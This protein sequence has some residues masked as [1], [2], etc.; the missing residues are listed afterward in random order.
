MGI[1]TIVC[2]SVVS[3]TQPSGQATAQVAVI[4]TGATG[5]QG[6]A[7]PTGATGPAG[8]TGATGAQGIPGPAGPA[9]AT[10]PA[11]ANGLNGA[12]GAIG[13][14]GATGPA[15]PTGDTGAAGAA[16][17]AGA[18]GVPGLPGAN[19]LPGATGLGLSFEIRRVLS[20]ALITLPAGNRSVVYLVTTP[21]SNVTLTLP[22]ASDAVSRFVTIVRVDRGRRVI[23]R[24]S[25]NEMV[26]GARAPIVMG[27]KYDSITL[28]S[29]GVEWVALIKQ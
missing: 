17:A 19:G 1:H 29:D 4:F 9:G 14:I 23:V 13:P 8:A 26:D 5:A 25:N 7:G 20:D 24:P 22:A 21:P 12:D 10:G 2:T 11:G 18:P 27:D 3:S 6:P 15:G 28:V 16:G